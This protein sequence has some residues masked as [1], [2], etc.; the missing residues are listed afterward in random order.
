MPSKFQYKQ[1]IKELESEVK[2]LELLL[3]KSVDVLSL[4]VLVSN[5]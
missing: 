4:A 5:K 3:E 2:K 1:R